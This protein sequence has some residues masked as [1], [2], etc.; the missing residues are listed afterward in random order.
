M[1]EMTIHSRKG[2]KTPKYEEKNFRKVV[3]AVDIPCWLLDWS[4]V[5]NLVGYGRKWDIFLH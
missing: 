3:G 1:P 2:G 4:G 5:T